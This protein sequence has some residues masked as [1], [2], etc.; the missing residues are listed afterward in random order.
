MTRHALTVDL[1]DW[2]QLVYRRVTGC[3]C[4]T[5]GNV[6]T[7]TH[8]V[9]DL[10]AEHDVRATFFVVGLVASAFPDLVAQVA[11]AGHEIGCHTGDHQT[12]YAVKPADFRADLERS[13]AQLQDL[14]G[15]PV[16]C[17]RAP[18]FS[19]GSLRNEAFFETLAE[20]GFQCDSSVFPVP[21]L[22]YGI[23]DAPRHPFAVPT[24]S[25][26]IHEF[27]L[28]TWAPGGCRL[29]VAGGTCYRFLPGRFLKRVVTDLD[30][31]GHTATFYLHPYEFHHGL[32]H[33]S[34]LT[35]HDRRQTAYV[36]HTV[37]HNLCSRALR[38]RWGSLLAEHRFV[39]IGEI[40]DGGPI[41]H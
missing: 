37:L 26:P 5:T 34:G 27:P 4:A 2:H 6:V 38:E 40:H 11:A 21:G 24:A 13:R 28:A 15:Q 36:R 25:G 12:L 7:D 9:L 22:R 39:P 23:P 30:T 19:V 8:R 33:L 10:L 3:A 17:F 41:T 31:D 20:A 32:L 16:L 35:W 29:P 14:T 1:E 18:A